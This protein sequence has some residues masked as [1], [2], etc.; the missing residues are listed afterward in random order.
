LKDIPHQITCAGSLEDRRKVFI[1]VR[2]LAKG[3][4]EFTVNGEKFK[5]NL[6]FLSSHDGSGSFFIFDSNTR[7]VCMNT[8]NMAMSNR[9]QSEL[10]RHARHTKGNEMKIQ[11]ISSEIQG[12]L[13]GREIFKTE[14]EKLAKIK[15]SEDEAMAFAVGLLFPEKREKPSN[16]VMESA[17]GIA[18]AFSRGDGNKGS[19]RYDLFNGVTQW[20]TRNTSRSDSDTYSSS[21]NGVG[22]TRKGQAFDILVDKDA[23]KATVQKGK[24][25]LVLAN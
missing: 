19:N 15:C 24:A 7:V 12:A 13:A 21:F 17:Q 4:A 22:A 20:F 3:N 10:R 14:C 2:L 11:A 8:F 5:A 16:Q 25:G 18:A 23:F 6:N 1:S 9:L